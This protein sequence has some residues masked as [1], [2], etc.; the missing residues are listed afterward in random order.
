MSEQIK[1]V[2]DVFKSPNVVINPIKLERLKTQVNKILDENIDL[3]IKLNKLDLT[4]ENV[5]NNLGSIYQYLCDNLICKACDKNLFNC[6]KAEHFGYFYE[7]D[8][9]GQYLK[10]HLSQCSLLQSQNKILSNLIAYEDNSLNVYLNSQKLL[11]LLSKKDNLY[12]L[13]SVA[14]SAVYISKHFPKHDFTEKGLALFQINKT[15]YISMLLSL[16][17]Y[18]NCRKGYKVAYLDAFDLLQLFTSKNIDKQELG[19]NLLNKASNANTLILSNLD[20]IPRYLRE[21]IDNYLFPLLCNRNK[22][23]KITYIDLGKYNS[24][25]A[26]FKHLFFHSTHLNEVLKLVDELF[27]DYIINDLS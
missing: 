14:K 1:K 11:N 12:L 16:A 17:A 23:N 25:T 4:S 8:A 19:A 20:Q 21:I 13:K 15:T 3:R 10:L 18:L 24:S 5:D 7:L 26:L 6:P 9:S 2:S 22:V 27:D